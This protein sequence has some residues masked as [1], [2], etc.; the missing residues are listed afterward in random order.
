MRDSGGAT[1]S[2][3][4]VERLRRE[5]GELW[6]WIHR[7]E[8]LAEAGLQARGLAHDLGNTLTSLMAGSELALLHEDAAHFREALEKNLTLSRQAAQRLHCFVDYTSRGGRDEQCG[9]RMREVVEEAIGFLA[10]PLRKACVEVERAY[11]SEGPVVGS[12]PELLQVVGNVLLAVLAGFGERGGILEV[13][14]EE[15]DARVRL[16]ARRVAGAAAGAGRGEWWARGTGLETTVARRIVAS[17]GGQVEM[18]VG[19]SCAYV[20]LPALDPAPPVRPRASWREAEAAWS[21][22]EV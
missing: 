18:E 10:H 15:E 12:H 2:F 20:L 16:E 22:Q 9:M 19:A 11:A 4:E 17:L 3:H 13:R 7:L 6:Q 14:V 8:R 21:A 1:R 5:Q